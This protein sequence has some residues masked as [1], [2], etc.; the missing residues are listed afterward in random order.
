M[1][2]FFLTKFFFP[3]VLL[4]YKEKFRMIQFFEELTRTSTNFKMAAFYHL[5]HI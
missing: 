2:A 3:S 4:P 1:K 5:A